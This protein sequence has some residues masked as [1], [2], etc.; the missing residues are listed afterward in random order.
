M[1]LSKIRLRTVAPL[2]FGAFVVVALVLWLLGEY[3]LMLLLAIGVVAV[4]QLLVVFLLRR[5]TRKVGTGRL[6]DALKR[7]ERAL[8]D[9]ESP[10]EHAERL[11][12]LQEAGREA[13]MAQHRELMAEARDEQQRMIADGQDAVRASIDGQRETLDRRVAELEHDLEIEHRKLGAG[14]VRQVQG[15]LALY[16]DLQ[17]GR[18]LPKT[19][20]WAATAD[21]LH[22][23]VRL[24]VD[25]RP[26][27]VLEVGGGDSTVLLAL[28]LRHVGHGRIVS[29]EHDEHYLGLTR[30]LVD[31]WGVADLVDL[32]HAPL[33]DV[34]I[35]DESWQWYDPAALPDGPIDLLFVDGP[36]GGLQAQSRYPAVP[37]SWNRLAAGAT[38]VLDDYAREHEQ[39]LVDRWLGEHPELS[40]VVEPDTKQTAILTRDGTLS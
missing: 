27:T 3:E 35:G 17:P 30:A 31:D 18:G 25:R 19:R 4:L 7:T 13:L 2:A 34:Q 39:A 38:I 20:P 26:T 6:L 37:L 9:I 36:P 24:V 16:E 21:L 1:N 32:R 11:L 22:T 5:L 40:L 12:L 10:P 29:L 33:V 23:M 15:V 8:A 14:V 28:A